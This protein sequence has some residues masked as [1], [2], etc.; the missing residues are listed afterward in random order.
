MPKAIG[1]EYAFL[2]I[3]AQVFLGFVRWKRGLN[4]GKTKP[5][6]SSRRFGTLRVFTRAT[7]IDRRRL[8][9]DGAKRNDRSIVRWSGI[10]LIA[11]G[12]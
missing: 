6:P 8:K 7:K 1:F 9:R 12:V 11:G 5:K 4:I 3:I 2:S 10:S